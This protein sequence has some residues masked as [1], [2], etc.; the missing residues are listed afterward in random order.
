[1][2]KTCRLHKNKAVIDEREPP[3]GSRGSQRLCIE[4]R[5]GPPVEQIRSPASSGHYT[6]GCHCFACVFAS[7]RAIWEAFVPDL[8]T[9]DEPFRPGLRVKGLTAHLGVFEMTWGPHGRATF[10]YGEERIA[11]RHTSSGGE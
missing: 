4:H 5:P 7:R 2:T 1:M 6:T 11:G 8:D 10:S 9:P 3:D